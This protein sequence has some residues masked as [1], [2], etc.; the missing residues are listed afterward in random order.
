MLIAVTR[1]IPNWPAAVATFGDVVVWPEKLPP[2]TAQLVE[3]AQG[4]DGLLSLL[5]EP[6]NG[7]VLDTLPSMPGREQ[8]CG[9]L[10]Q[11]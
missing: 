10:R 3:F 5:T 8:F 7:A 4:A 6:I 2:T 9:W 1:D 11:Y